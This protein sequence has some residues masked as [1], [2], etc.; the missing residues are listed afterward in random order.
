MPEPNNAEILLY[1]VWRA[2]GVGGFADI[3]KIYETAYKIAP[4][5]FGW[6]SRPFPSDY[7]A[8]RALRLVLRSPEFSSLLLVSENRQGLQLTAE[9]VAWVRE[10][11]ARFA[12]A[13]KHAG[14]GARGQQTHR[15][16]VALE[17]DQIAQSYAAGEE[18][19]GGPRALRRLARVDSRC[20]R[21]RMAC[22]A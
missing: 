20:R 2:D 8:D 13:T 19:G 18:V 7:S 16:M 12:G 1:A 21:Q 14:P 15:R 11:E 5:R 10:N 6:R 17:R 9:G 22:A 3:E 4:S